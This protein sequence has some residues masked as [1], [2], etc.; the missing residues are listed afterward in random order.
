MDIQTLQAVIDKLN[1]RVEYCDSMMLWCHQYEKAS[2]DNWI[3]AKLEAKESVFIVERMLN[4][5]D[6]FREQ[7]A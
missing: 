7:T 5:E 1:E 3:H 6:T 4:K 2:T